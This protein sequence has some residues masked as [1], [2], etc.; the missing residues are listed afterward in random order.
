MEPREFVSRI[1]SKMIN[2]SSSSNGLNNFSKMTKEFSDNISDFL[3]SVHD[4][5]SKCCVLLTGCVDHLIE[6]SVKELA[7]TSVGLL[8]S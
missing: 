6:S 2:R 4:L 7:K 1:V 8:L 3:R 5:E